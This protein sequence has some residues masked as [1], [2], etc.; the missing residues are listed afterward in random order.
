MKVDTQ[1]VNPAFQ[2]I[3]Q[4]SG[5]KVTSG[6]KRINPEWRIFIEQMDVLYSGVI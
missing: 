2:S 3:I 1:A 5:Q 6:D 4:D